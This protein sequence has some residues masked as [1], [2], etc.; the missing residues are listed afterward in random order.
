MKKILLILFAAV[1]AVAACESKKPAADIEKKVDETLAQ[2]TLQ[3]K[4]KL[5]HAQSKFSSAGVPRLGIP[6]FWTSD[7]PHGVRPDVLWDKWRQADH[8]DDSCTAFPAL[9][10]LA[11]TWNTE[12]AT[13]YGKSIGEEA[14]YRRKDVLLAP[15]L[16]ILRHPLGGRNF[17]YMG[18]DPY[19]TGKMAVNYIQGVQS[20]KVA[21]CVKHYALNND[22]IHRHTANVVID[23]RTLY[24]IY[25]PA[26]KAAVQEGGA[27]SV[28]GSYNLYKDQHCCHNQYLLNDILKGEWGFDGA[29][30]SDW[31]G[32]HDTDQA[33]TN[34]LD[35]E[36]GTVTK[37]LPQYTTNPYDSYYLALPYQKKIEAGEYG[38]EELDEKVRRVLRLMY[39]TSMAEN[40][41]SGEF[42]SPGHFA[43]ARR[44]GAEGIVL[45]KNEGNLLPVKNAGKILVVGEN[46][47]KM[48]TVG[49]GSSSLKA[50]HEISPLQGIREAFPDA[51]VS[52]ERGYD[53]H[54]GDSFDG[55]FAQG[56]M[57][58]TRDDATLLADAVKAAADADIVL[59]VGGLN[60]SQGQDAE[61]D[62]RASFGLPYGQDEVIEALAEANPNLV[63]INISGNP[64]GMPWASKVPAILQDWYLGSE[65]G[66][67]LADVLTGKVNPSGH[68]PFTIPVE[69]EDGPVTSESQYPGIPRSDSNLLDEYYSEG[70]YVGYRWF[71]TQG[72]AP[73]FA[74]GHGLSYTT[75]EYGEP[76]LSAKTLAGAGFWPATVRSDAKTGKG[77]TVTLSVRNTGT[78]AGAEVVQLYLAAEKSSIDRPAKEL[79]GFAKVFLEPGQRADVNFTIDPRDLAY[80]DAEKHG[81]TAEAGSYLVQVGSSSR[82]IRAAAS[83]TLK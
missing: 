50:L 53:S 75:F 3:E 65:A 78:L 46:A 12:L 63:V 77:L 18:E 40:R 54:T 64:V 28:M 73:R 34:G 47:V 43:A 42:I 30:I 70:V 8:T 1:L 79:K 72:S 15:G 41:P 9:T 33:I 36:F 17:E 76:R 6:T 13:L 62:D 81:W 20:N 39:R 11:A 69:M 32:C 4:I 56:V 55:V 68:L 35:L 10:C 45:L 27:W 14:R 24:E 49:G 44:I 61:D 57:A 5:I 23:D 7:G 22:E 26:F 21:V 38:T 67:S 48:L 80:F 71:D 52:F 19:L 16:N 59:F 66:R 31:G 82:D 58:E 60:K 83:F 51:E 25:L 37:N 74:F 2:L 29:V